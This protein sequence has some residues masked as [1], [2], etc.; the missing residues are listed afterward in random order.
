MNGHRSDFKLYISGESNKMD[1]KVLYDHL[2]SHNIVSFNVQILDTLVTSKR[3]V[4]K[5]HEMLN[6]REKQW[7]WKLDTVIPKGLNSD[8][9]FFSHNKKARKTR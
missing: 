8:D 3:S 2:R 9:C 4:D 7:I 5:L 1:H 6:D